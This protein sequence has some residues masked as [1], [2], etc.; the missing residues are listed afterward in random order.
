MRSYCNMPKL[1][2]LLSQEQRQILREIK[3]KCSLDNFNNQ[4]G[5]RKITQNSQGRQIDNYK[6]KK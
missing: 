1:I 4:Y 2:E 3:D 6:S 5:K